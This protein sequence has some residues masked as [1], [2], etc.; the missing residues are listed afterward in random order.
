[1][2]R[3]EGHLEPN[4]VLCARWENTLHIIYECEK[5]R[6]TLGILEETIHLLQEKMNKERACN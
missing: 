4:W 2:G 6:N 3:D 5:K 1:V